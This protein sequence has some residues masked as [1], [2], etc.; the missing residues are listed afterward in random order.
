[1]QDSFASL[2]GMADRGENNLDL[3]CL[4]VEIGQEGKRYAIALAHAILKTSVVGRTPKTLHDVLPHLFLN[5]SFSNHFLNCMT[6]L[7]P[8]TLYSLNTNHQNTSNAF[9][10]QTTLRKIV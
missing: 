2:S 10:L 3:M 5:C 8:S 6:C 1:M 7:G 9:R 4:Y